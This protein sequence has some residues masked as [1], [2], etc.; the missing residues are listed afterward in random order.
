MVVESGFKYGGCGLEL[1]SFH[2]GLETLVTQGK[3]PYLETLVTK[4]KL[5]Y[6]ETLVT[7]GKLPYLET[8]V[9]MGSFHVCICHA[10]VAKFTEVSGSPDVVTA[11]LW[12]Q[13]IMAKN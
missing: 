13:D 7:N 4:A 3:L 11:V 1:A 6:L 5:P 12:S 10:I 8:L 9:T 2:L